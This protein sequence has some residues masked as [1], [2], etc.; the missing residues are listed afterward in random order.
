M[1]PTRRALYLLAAG[2]PVSLFLVM[3]NQGW[4][5]VA[6]VWLLIV[7]IFVGLDA[8]LAL[9]PAD[10]HLEMR[11]PA[12][13]YIGDEDPLWLRAGIGDNREALEIEVIVDL[14][15]HLERLDPVRLSLTPGDMLD[16]AF[17]LIPLERGMGHVHR[18][19][20]RWR[21]PIGLVMR[22]VVHEMDLGIPIGPDVRT[23]RQAAIEFFSRDARLGLKAQNE[24]GSGSEFHALR[25][26]VS[27][28][29]HRFIDWKHSAR[30][31]KLVAKEFRTERN[32][33][34]VLAMDTGHLMQ[35]PLGRIS[36]LD[37][38]INAAL[39]VGYVSLRFGDRIGVLG[40]DSKVRLYADPV[41]GAQSYV[42]LQRTMAELAHRPEETNFTLGLTDLAARL[43]RRSLVILMS[44]FVD[45]TTAELMLE[46][47]SRLVRRHLV[48]F[49]TFRDP[50]LD[51]T[52]Q[53]E[54]DDFSD[55][56][57][58]VVAEDFIRERQTVLE[59]LRRMGV[60]IVDSPAD[61]LTTNVLNRYLSI[62]QRE[63]I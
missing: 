59:R 22:Q 44:E 21:G 62:Q 23:V 40:F 17:P 61:T 8:V 4:W 15:E 45:V 36:R 63:L 37:H 38:A 25:E 9:R 43:N 29:E 12:L 13:L 50:A 42:H 3:S 16:H 6:L 60:L 31:R 53:A 24:T 58:A 52:A 47:V 46:N 28:M 19:S 51:M 27:G 26:Y 14:D 5:I 48:L 34:I 2:L 49:V 20:V 11:E 55:V 39:M 35:E 1:Y 10:L 32:H 54:P 57:R 18:V 56:T 30:H 41:G 7:L 33:Q